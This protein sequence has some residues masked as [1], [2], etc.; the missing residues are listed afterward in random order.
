MGRAKRCLGTVG[1]L[2]CAAILAACTQGEATDA[3]AT[4]ANRAPTIDGTPVTAA[5]EDVPYSFTPT[6]T[7]P[8]G[9]PL[10]FGVDAKPVWAMFNTS[11]AQLSGTPTSA[12]V[13][14]YRGVVIWVSDGKQ[15]TLLPAFD[16]TVNS[17]S[18]GTNGPP[19]ISGT[20]AVSVVAGAAYTFKPTASDPNNDALTFSIR[21]RPAWATFSPTDGKLTGT[22][23]VANV[24]TFADIVIS[25][26]DG[27]AAVSLPAFTIVVTPPASNAPP[28]ISGV[29]MTSVAAGIA[30]SF[31][32]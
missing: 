18:S 3:A 17:T 9:D 20:P 1:I 31:V 24:G 14:V 22:P 21:N 10:I 29:P 2:L 28:T 8:D 15:Q 11:T 13:G 32:P 25:V 5:A 12:N 30:Y 27:Q 23:L 26:S 4:G 16:L 6:A 7:D 19:T